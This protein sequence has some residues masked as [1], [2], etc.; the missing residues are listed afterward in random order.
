MPTLRRAVVALALAALGISTVPAAVGDAYR[1][2]NV[3]NAHFSFTAENW[4]NM[5]PDEPTQGPFGR[6][7]FGPG[8]FLA[9]SLMREGDANADSKVSKAEFGGLAEKLFTKWDTNRAGVIKQDDLRSGINALAGPMPG[10]GGPGG[11]G[12]RP[13]GIPLQGAQGK[14]NGLASASGVEFDYVPANIEIDGQAFTNVAVRYKGNGT[15][16]NSRNTDKR[17]LKADLNDFVRGQKFHGVAKLNFHNSVTDA[18]YMNEVLGYRLYRDAGVPAPRSAY[19]R[20]SVTVPGTFD[21]QYLGLYSTIEN[22]DGNFAEYHFRAKQGAIFKPVTREPFTDLGNDWAAY[23]QVYDPKTDLTAA[24]K[25]RVI[26]FSKLVSHAEDGEFAQKLGEFVDLDNLARYMAVTTWISTMDS[27]LAIGQNYYVYLHPKTGKFHFI[28]WDLDHAFGQFSL[29][30]TQELREN[31]SIH[32]PWQGEIRLLERIYKVPAFKDLY[33]ARLREFSETIFR[34]E[35]LLKQVDEVA[36]AIRPA[37]VDES[38][39]KLARFDKVVAGEAVPPDMSGFGPPPGP[40]G[41]GAP[42]GGGDVLI[43]GGP[44]RPGGPGGPGGFGAP[45][46]GPGGPGGGMRFGGPPGMMQPAKP[47]KPF[48]AARA[49][50]VKDQLKGKSEGQKIDFGF[51]G[52]GGMRGFGP[53]MFMGPAFLNELDA[54]KNGELSK[55]EF[56]EGFGRW[57][58]KWDAG[59]SGSLDETQLLA[60]LNETFR[61]PGF[62]PGGPGSPGGP[63][64]P[65]N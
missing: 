51:G 40:R 8:M 15:W 33:L 27:I 17:S 64:P 39:T 18:S 20:V 19:A 11:P 25:Q 59:K 49:A 37:V 42:G 7:G 23:Q 62:G 63:R 54:D 5:M 26:D 4:Q 2:T 3:W 61:P 46:Q 41:P 10:P 29:L 28:P 45:G 12:G 48:V 47:I 13:G 1:F 35:R 52:P 34:P 50:S 22:V 24:Q 32:K 58:E 53:G 14:R 6:G 21:R 9:P 31:L 16:M 30:G 38:E 55:T 44:G 65:G 60:G 57:F 36:A 43:A 56:S